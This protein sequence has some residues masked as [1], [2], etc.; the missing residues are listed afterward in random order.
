LLAGF[1][2]MASQALYFRALAISESGTVAAYWN[3][4]PVLL[5]LASY[6]FLGEQLSSI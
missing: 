3:L 1:A 6:L 5:L 2:F 4:L